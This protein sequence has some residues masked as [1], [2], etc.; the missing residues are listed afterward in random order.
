MPLKKL[1]FKPGVNRE[2]TRYTTEGGWY[3]CDKIRFRQ[4]TPEKIGGWQQISASTFLGTCRSLWPWSTLGAVPFIGVGTNLK[5]YVYYDGSYNDITPIRSTSTRAN[6]FQTTVSSNVVRVNDA[7]HGCIT[8]DFV[9]IAGAS[10]VS[11]VQLTGAYQ[12]TVLDANSYTVVAAFNA[13]ASATGGGPAV[14]FS[15]EITTGYA[16]PT[17]LSGWGAAAWSSGPWG[18]GATSLTRTFRRENVDRQ[19]LQE[20]IGIVSK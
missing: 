9:T 14:T 20:C 12:V 10:A 17:L 1:V 15:Y 8:G 3:D 2:N 7:G 6:P 16:T 18:Q 19:G 11:G 5:Y 13:L 4:G